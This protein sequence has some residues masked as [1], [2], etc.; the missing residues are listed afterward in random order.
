MQIDRAFWGPLAD[1]VERKHAEKRP[2]LIAA[3]KT[4]AQPG[5]WARIRADLLPMLRPPERV[6]DCLER[7]NAAHRIE[8]LGLPRA[9]YRAALAHAHEIRSRFTVLDLAYLLGLMPDA[10]DDLLDRWA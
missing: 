9:R 7:A 8:D 4:L 2:R 5:V 3:K 1:E 6:R 10:I